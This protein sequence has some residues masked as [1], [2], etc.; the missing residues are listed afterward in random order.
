MARRTPHLHVDLTPVY[1]FNG[2]L[3]TCQLLGDELK[4]EQMSRPLIDDEYGQMMREFDEAEEWMKDQLK[5]KQVAATSERFV[6]S[7]NLPGQQLS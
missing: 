6:R 7:E 2:S 4:P 1:R 5:A 3:G